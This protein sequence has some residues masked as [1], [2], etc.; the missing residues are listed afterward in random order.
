MCTAIKSYPSLFIKVFF[1]FFAVVRNAMM[2]MLIVKT[3]IYPSAPSATLCADS[4][5]GENV[6]LYMMLF[7]SLLFF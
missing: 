6:I 2:M 1:E 7:C 5:I 4:L 3:S